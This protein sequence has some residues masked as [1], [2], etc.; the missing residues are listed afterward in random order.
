MFDDKQLHSAEVKIFLD[1]LEF[2]PVAEIAYDR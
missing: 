2:T 1:F